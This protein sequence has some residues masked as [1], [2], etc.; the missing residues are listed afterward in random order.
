MIV[1]SVTSL[2]VYAAS[3]GVLGDLVHVKFV[4]ATSGMIPTPVSHSLLLMWL[5]SVVKTW[6]SSTFC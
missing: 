1:A 2:S 5:V 4:L 6:F 3:V